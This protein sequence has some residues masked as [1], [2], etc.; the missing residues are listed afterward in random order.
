MPLEDQS[1][2]NI[3][4]VL[5]NLF[6]EMLLASEHSNESN[7]NADVSQYLTALKEHSSKN[8]SDSFDFG[9]LIKLV[10]GWRSKLNLTKP[11]EVSACNYCDGGFREF[12]LAYNSVHGYVSLI[13]SIILDLVFR[14]KKKQ[15]I[16]LSTLS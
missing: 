4:Q 11:T 9:T 13:V 5:S 12:V 16:P 10:D 6:G 3:T 14:N 15:F 8:N 1:T 2:T 7:S